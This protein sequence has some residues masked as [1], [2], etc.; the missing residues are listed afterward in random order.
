MKFKEESLKDKFNQVHPVLRKMAQ[1]M[2]TFMVDTYDKELTITAAKSSLEEDTKLGR[3]S[4]SHR[5]GRAIDLRIS[6]LNDGEIATL[7]QRFST[8]WLRYAAI[9]YSGASNFMI[10]KKDHIHTQI[11]HLTDLEVEAFFLDWA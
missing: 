9:S 10:V 5:E 2:D 8:L 7:T 1:Y 4:A 6:D 11:K 3:V